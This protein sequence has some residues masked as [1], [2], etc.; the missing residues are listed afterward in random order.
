MGSL[1]EG[2]DDLHFDP[3]RDK[4]VMKRSPQVYMYTV[5]GVY[6]S[7]TSCVCTAHTSTHRLDTKK[8]A[9]QKFA[10]RWFR[11]ID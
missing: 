7:S 4:T 8:V 9:I 5:C 11:T 10:L 6:N 1:A 2:V 3:Y